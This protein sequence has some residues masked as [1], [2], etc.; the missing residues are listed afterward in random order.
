MH[1]TRSLVTVL[2]LSFA[3]TSIAACPKSEIDDKPKAKVE[4][5]EKIDPKPPGEAKSDA[6]TLALASEGSSVGF[7]G[8]KV[9]GDHKGSF[10]KFNGT[11]TVEGDKLT[12]MEI[13]VEVGSMSTDDEKLTGHLLDTDFFEAAT[14]PQAKFTS[15]SISEKPGEGGATHE[16]VGNL[17]LKG[18]AK[19]ITFPATIHVKDGSVHST[20]A[21][22]INRKDWGINYAGQPDNLIKD[23]VALELELSFPRA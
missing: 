13:I 17:E 11:A 15:L 21:F 2:T 4:E 19:K 8:A 23:D 16:V 3:L 6:M 7:I 20:A 12:G 22:S 5:A 10:A 9:T 14:Y 1:R 18:Q